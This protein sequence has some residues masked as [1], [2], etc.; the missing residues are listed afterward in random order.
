MRTLREVREIAY[1]KCCKAVEMRESGMLYREIGQE[2]G[3]SLER[4]R[5]YVKNIDRKRKMLQRSS[6]KAP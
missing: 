2:M 3:V 5:Q 6:A 1:A 4:A